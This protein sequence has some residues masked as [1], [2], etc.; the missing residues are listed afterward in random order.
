MKNVHSTHLNCFRLSITGQLYMSSFHVQK[1][2]AGDIDVVKVRALESLHVLNIKLILFS[3][4]GF[5]SLT[6]PFSISTWWKYA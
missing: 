1:T 3:F 2:Q 4:F 6:K 5:Y